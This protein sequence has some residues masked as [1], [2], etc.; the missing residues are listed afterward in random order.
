[1]T[2]T[3][4]TPAERRTLR[5]IER[6]TADRG[7]PPTYR[8]LARELGVTSSST[9]RY[10]VDGLVSKG[11]INREDNTARGLRVVNQ[12]AQYGRAMTEREQQLNEQAHLYASP[13]R[14][15]IAH[16][17]ADGAFTDVLMTKVRI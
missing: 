13:D 4:L 8:E 12:D 10:A 5:V 6:F 7:I 15:T 9:S 17:D 1:M 16:T 11:Y 3:R 2:L 14:L